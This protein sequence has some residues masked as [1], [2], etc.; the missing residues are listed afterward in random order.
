MTPEWIYLLKVN[1]GIALFYAFYKLFCQRDTFFVWRRFALLSFMAI[2][3]IYP[4]L[5]IQDWVKEQPA[6]YELADYYATWM[7]D[8]EV[9]V[10]V[11][12][13][14]TQS[15]K[16]PS[17]MVIGMYIY[18]IGVITLTLR[19]L[20]QLLSIFRIR[21]TGT[22]TLLNGQRIISIPTDVSPF[23]FFG[24][25]FLHLPNIQKDN[26]QEIM[27]HEQTHVR[28]WHSVDVVLS[29]LL[30]IICWFNPFM[31]LLKG[32]IR[33]NLEYLADNKV[34]ETIHNNK[35]YQ[36][37]LLGLAHTKQ[38]IGLYNNF[39]VS[40]LKKRIIMMNKKRT[41]MTGRIKYA[42]FAPLAIALLLASN[43]SCISNEKKNEQ[44]EVPAVQQAEAPTSP[45]ETTPM[46][47][48]A[49]VEEVF[50][51]V[52]EMPEYPG[53]MAAAMKWIANELKYPAI[54][55]ENGVQGRVTVRFIINKDGSVSDAIVAKGVDP[56]LDKEAL[57]VISKMP[58]WKPGK[59]RGQAV[60]VSYN[61]PVRF[62][63][64]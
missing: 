62:K 42:L 44:A 39:N 14:A 45:V 58:N 48:E 10:S 27:M 55:Q 49:T 21:R 2:S 20:T 56:H 63:L 25:I 61:L 59:Q 54:A 12:A 30:C 18:Y 29:E 50:T 60:R 4:L 8:Q 40:H 32:E 1:V 24:W 6:M 9:N 13:T 51:M 46:N 5:N 43:I 22:T 35:Q 28:Q 52:E 47:N 7:S 64:N 19:F 31:W 36:Y 16:L 23:S 41:R 26:Q 33:L 37:H 53:G 11:N 15:A 17:L 38:Q 34:S 3:F 57:R